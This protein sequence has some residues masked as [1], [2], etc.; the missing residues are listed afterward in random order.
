MTSQSWRHSV[1]DV[2]PHRAVTSLFVRDVTQSLAPRLSLHDAALSLVLRVVISYSCVE[3]NIDE[4]GRIGRSAFCQRSEHRS[5][6]KK[7]R[8]SVNVWPGIDA[9][10][11]SG[12]SA[13][14]FNGLPDSETRLPGDASR[15]PDVFT[16]LPSQRHRTAKRCRG[17]Q[18]RMKL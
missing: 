17:G 11:T 16:G 14:V 9:A 5:A 6:D 2:T 3:H 10:K 7:H 12:K 8:D 1:R 15:L 13:Q 18:Y 4:V